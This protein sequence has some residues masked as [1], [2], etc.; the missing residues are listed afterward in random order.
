MESGYEALECDHLIVTMGENGIMLL[1]EREDNGQNKP[2]IDFIPAFAEK[3]ENVSGAVGDV[4]LTVT[5]MSVAAGASIREAAIGSVA[6]SV[7]VE[8]PECKFLSS[9]M[10]QKKLESL[11]ISIKEARLD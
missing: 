9:D 10:L 8:D 11:E 5:S 2:F 7:R 3:V 4:F 1:S 6:A